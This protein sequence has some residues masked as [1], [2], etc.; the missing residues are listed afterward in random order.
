[1]HKI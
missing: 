1:M